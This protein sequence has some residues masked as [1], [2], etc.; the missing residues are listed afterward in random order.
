MS[1]VAADDALRDGASSSPSAWQ[2]LQ[3]LLRELPHMVSD[4]VELLSLELQ[5]AGQAL[6]RIVLL[7]VA[8][9]VLVVTAWLAA[10][11]VIYLL[12]VAAGMP[13]LAA[14]VLVLLCNALAAW[15]ALKHAMKLV[16]LLGLPATRRHL[17]VAA[18]KAPP[19]DQALRAA[20]DPAERIDTP[21][22]AQGTE[23]SASSTRSHAPPSAEMPHVHDAQRTVAA[24]T[25]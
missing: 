19:L 10:W 13:P 9:A 23:Q 11:G 1:V 14:L 24:A 2:Q 7:V 21:C 5:R 17:T 18:H 3:Q 22:V 16:S 4:R 8:A 25:H 15:M 12:L 20:A 6:A